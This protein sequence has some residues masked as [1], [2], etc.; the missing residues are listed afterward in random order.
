MLVSELQIQD[1]YLIGDEIIEYTTVSS[2]VIGGNIVRGTNSPKLI[3]SELQFI[4]M[5]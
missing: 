3:Q 2:G 4:S 5:N 1:I